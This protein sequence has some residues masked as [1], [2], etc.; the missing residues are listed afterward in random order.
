MDNN[1]NGDEI[2]EMR[3]YVPGT[4][5]NETTIVK[6]ETNGDVIEEAV[7]NETSAAQQFYE[8]LKDKADIGQV[9]GEAIVSFS[10]VLFLTPRGRYDIDMYPSSLR[11]RVK[12]MITKYSTNRLKESSVYLNPMKHIT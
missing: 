1:K 3:F 4:I 9:A 6:N 2:V 12:L 8:Q 11:L 7:V 5:E 10:D